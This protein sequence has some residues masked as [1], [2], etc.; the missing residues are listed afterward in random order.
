MSFKIA[1]SQRLGK[2]Q[3]ITTAENQITADTT[4]GKFKVTVY[5]QHVIRVAITCNDAFEDFSYAVVASPEGAKINVQNSDDHLTI[6]TSTLQLLID[7]NPARFSFQTLEGKVINEDDVL[8]A[9]WIGEQVTQYKKLQDGERFLGLG[10]KTGNLDRRGHGYQNWNTDAYA[11]HAGT[12]P[13]YS[14][15][16]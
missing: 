10:E 13:L 14:S 7:K 1:T 6:K 2:I 9:S 4:L 15:I 11:Y 3:N 5:S 12:D 8:G 16:P